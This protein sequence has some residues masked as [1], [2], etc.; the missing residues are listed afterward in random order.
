MKT[1]HLIP[2]LSKDFTNFLESWS[3]VNICR[4]ASLHKRSNTT[5]THHRG[6]HVMLQ[7]RLF[8]V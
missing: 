4:Q 2:H 5:R 8:V 6:L 3:V 7:R 1:V